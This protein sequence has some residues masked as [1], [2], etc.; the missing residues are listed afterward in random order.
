MSFDVA[1]DAYDAFMGRY[2]RRLSAGFIELA[3]VTTGQRVLDVGCGPG[4]LT[5]DLASLLGASA[6][7]AVDPSAPFVEAARTRL[8]DID[9]RLAAAES[10]PFPD[11]AFDAVLAQVVVHFLKDPVRGL[12]EM[13]R[14][15]R[16]GGVIAASVWDHAGGK[17]PL[18]TFWS[19]ARELDDAVEDESGL[20]GARAG[21]LSEL[22]EQAGL[23]DVSETT[24][25]ADLEH[26]TFEAWWDPFT[27]GVGPAGAYVQRLD[28]PQR[29]ALRARC[30]EILGDGPF[31]IPA[32]A[33]AARGRTP[34][35]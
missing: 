2:S 33:W 4:V 16:S 17:G 18:G 24:L 28:P 25:V 3:G 32:R 31:V 7:V 1:G 29:T 5:A 23:L 20:P 19:A 22:F 10:L 6:V 15:A 12:R 35:G 34:A 13:A 27:R 9:V 21:H 11:G 30:H 26:P 14:V 8:P